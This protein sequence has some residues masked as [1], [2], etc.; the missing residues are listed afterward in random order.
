MAVLSGYLSITEAAHVL[1]L[2]RERVRVLTDDRRLAAE[3]VAGRWVVPA[4]AVHQFANSRRRGGR[5]LSAHRVWELINSGFV[6]RLLSTADD[7]A[8]RNIRVQ[9]ANR[10]QVIDVFVLPQFIGKVGPLV[11][12]GGRALAESAEVV[13]GRDLRWELDGYIRQGTVERLRGS[14]RISGVGGEPNVRL[15]VVEDDMRWSETR[16]N[17]LVVAW[18]DLADLGDRAAEVTLG[19]MVDEVRRSGLERF[20]IGN[21]VVSRVSLSVLAA[22]NDELSR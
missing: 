15:R 20:P 14:K 2:S 10:A 6:A 22:L 13:A 4:E 12:P 16:V 7:G 21:D 3:R 19:A 1:G 18:L 5:P 17:R 11:L 8:Q 9:L